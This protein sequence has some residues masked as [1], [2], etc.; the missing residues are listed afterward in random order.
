MFFVH[1]SRCGKAVSN[2][3]PYE[4]IV[5]AYVECPECLGKEDPEKVEPLTQEKFSKE[6]EERLYK[7]Y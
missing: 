2:D 6:M 1:C 3:L 7:F 5:R 4:G